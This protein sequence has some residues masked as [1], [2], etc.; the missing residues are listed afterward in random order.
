[1][2]HSSNYFANSIYKEKK[3]SPVVLAFLVFQGNME[4]NILNEPKWF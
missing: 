2:F 1:M 4:K 3:G